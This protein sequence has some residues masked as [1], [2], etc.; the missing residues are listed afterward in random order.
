[1]QIQNL[2]SHTLI[3]LSNSRNRLK[4]FL[5]NLTLKLIFDHLIFIVHIIIQ[6]INRILKWFN[7]LLQK[8]SRF[9]HTLSLLLGLLQFVLQLLAKGV[10]VVHLG[11]KLVDFYVEFFAV[12]TYDYYKL[13]WVKD[14]V[15]DCLMTVSSNY[16]YFCMHSFN[17]YMNDYGLSMLSFYNEN[18]GRCLWRCSWSF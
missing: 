11:L 18:D 13:N 16:D 2:R 8:S 7:F 5:N 4:A 1:M 3:F 17:V 15:L 6:T 10:Q 14:L 9:T 12:V